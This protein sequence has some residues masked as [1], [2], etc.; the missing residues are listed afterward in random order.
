[1]APLGSL[2]ALQGIGGGGLGLGLGLAGAAAAAQHNIAT[3]P[4]PAGPAAAAEGGGDEV[5]AAMTE[6]FRA[7]YFADG[8]VP[9]CAPPLELVTTDWV[10]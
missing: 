7:Q 10:Q 6:G 1:M 5:T 9:L 8:L 3:P 2:T 4:A